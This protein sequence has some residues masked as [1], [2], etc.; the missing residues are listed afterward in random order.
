MHMW[1]VKWIKMRKLTKRTM[2][3]RTVAFAN[4][5]HDTLL[6]MAV[7]GRIVNKTI[8]SFAHNLTWKEC[9]L[10][11]FVDETLCQLRGREWDQRIFNRTVS[12]SKIATRLPLSLSLF[13]MYLVWITIAMYILNATELFSFMGL[14]TDRQLIILL[15]R[16]FSEHLSRPREDWLGSYVETR[17]NRLKNTKIMFCISS[18]KLPLL[19]FYVISL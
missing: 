11:E 1:E 15:P 3:C 8:V 9:K 18:D 16:L 13:R 2:S 12:M 5:L 19:A 6:T 4:F 10:I 7:K 14:A 17:G